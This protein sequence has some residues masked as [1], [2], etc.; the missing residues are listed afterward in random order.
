MPKEVYAVPYWIDDA[1]L[2]ESMLRSGASELFVELDD[3]EKRNLPKVSATAKQTSSNATALTFR[4]GS[5]A[6]DI[7]NPVHSEKTMKRDII[8]MSIED[9]VEANKGHTGGKSSLCTDCC[10]GANGFCSTCTE[11]CMEDCNQRFQ[12]DEDGN[13]WFSWAASAKAERMNTNKVEPKLF[14]SNERTFIS[15]LQMA[16]MMTS[17]AVTI[18]AFAATDGKFNIYRFFFD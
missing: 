8:P 14:F 12:A 10:T 5:T 13:G 11:L 7:K 4:G 15:W 17:I 3:N 16:V 9:D 1:S 2:K 18:S 6:G